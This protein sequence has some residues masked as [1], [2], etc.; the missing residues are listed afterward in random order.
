LN[1]LYIHNTQ[2]F[3]KQVLGGARAVLD[4]ASKKL[5]ELNHK[6]KVEK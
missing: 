3:S 1:T 6:L 2:R 5:D 4:G